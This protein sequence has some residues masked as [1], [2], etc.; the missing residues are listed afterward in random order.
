MRIQFELDQAMA[1]LRRLEGQASSVNDIPLF[2]AASSILKEAISKEI[3]SNSARIDKVIS[4]MKTSGYD[5]RV[6][7]NLKEAQD[8]M[9][10][11]D[12]ERKGQYKSK[13]KK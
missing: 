12:G 1:V 8:R 5:E 9:K 2:T 11:E 7:S 4:T 3:D 13:L 10:L 6:V